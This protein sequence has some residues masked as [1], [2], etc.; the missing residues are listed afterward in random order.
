[1][2]RVQRFREGF[3]RLPP[4]ARLGECYQGDRAR[5]LRLA[6]EAGWV[7]A[8]ELRAVGVDFSFA[9]VVDLGRQHGGVIG[10]RAFARSA[11]TVAELAEAYMRG[12][13]EAGM[14]ACAKHFPGHGGVVEDSHLTLPQDPRDYASLAASDLVPFAR[15]V[16]AGVPAVMSAH[17]LYPQVAPLPATYSSFWLGEVL[18]KRMGFQGVVISDDLS[19]AGAEDVGDHAER[20]R[21]ALEA[22]CD[23]LLV[24]NAPEVQASVLEALERFTDP[25]SQLRR[26]RLHGRHPTDPERLRREPRWREAVRLLAGLDREPL[27]D[28][29]L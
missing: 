1:G 11:D 24:C 26:A 3:T 6:S 17:I 8:S 27:L 19:M 4:V 25:V 16:R 22:G 20:A 7:M 2:G 10:D 29:D 21:L 18:R 23:M 12:M 5:A 9:P 15:L 13:H 28:M 14:A